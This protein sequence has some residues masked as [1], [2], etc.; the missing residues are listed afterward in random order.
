MAS[1]SREKLSGSTN[2]K[3]IKV[4]ATAIGSGTTIH[5][6]IAGTTAWDEIYLWVTNTDTNARL[7][8]LSFGATTDPD[9]LICKAVSIPAACA[10]IPILTGQILQNGL[11]VLAACSV[12]DLLLI[13]GYVNRIA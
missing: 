8:T 12:A 5:T 10:P 1:Y 4:A 6:A 9:G 2:G 13:S 11:A 3:P 7:L